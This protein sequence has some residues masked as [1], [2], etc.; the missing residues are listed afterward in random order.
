[1]R[2]LGE[3]SFFLSRMHLCYA[4]LNLGGGHVP[5]RYSYQP[6]LTCRRDNYRR[7]VPCAPTCIVRLFSCAYIKFCPP[8]ITT[9]SSCI[10]T[11]STFPS[12]LHGCIPLLYDYA[13]GKRAGAERRRTSRRRRRKQARRRRGSEA[14]E[15][16]KAGAFSGV[17]LPGSGCLLETAHE[18]EQRTLRAL[19]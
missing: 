15:G 4:R 2:A 12:S 3:D 10:L 13:T 7:F 6:S 18:N 17:T 19:I 5:H 1:V 8:T 16:R 14:G 11:T 9:Y